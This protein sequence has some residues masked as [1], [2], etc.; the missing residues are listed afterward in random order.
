MYTNSI[1]EYVFV[2]SVIGKEIITNYVYHVSITYIETK[3]SEE[4][5]Y[6]LNNSFIPNVT[7][8]TFSFIKLLVNKLF[9][10]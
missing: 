7:V 9:F 1:L 10:F 2:E 3:N 5:T 8:E 6:T 4:H